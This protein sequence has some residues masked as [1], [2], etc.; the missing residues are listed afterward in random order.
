MSNNKP[1]NFDFS[2]MTKEEV[3]AYFESQNNKITKEYEKKLDSVNKQLKTS[4]KNLQTTSKKLNIKTK[5]L[6]TKTKELDSAN[7]K[8]KDQENIINSVITY[9]N[10]ETQIVNEIAQKTVAEILPLDVSEA[11]N[12]T[13]TLKDLLHECVTWSNKA[14]AYFEMSSLNKGNEKIPALSPKQEIDNKINDTKEA[15]DNAVSLREIQ[16]NQNILN[17]VT[18]AVA[19]YLIAKKENNEP[20]SEA[21]QNLIDIAKKNVKGKESKK[22]KSPG[23]QATGNF[24]NA[25]KCKSKTLDYCPECHG[26]LQRLSDITHNL[27]KDTSNLY[28][29]IEAI[30]EIEFLSYCDHCGKVFVYHDQDT[31]HPVLPNRTIDCRTLVN[32]SEALFMGIPLNKAIGKM[33]EKFNLGN[34]IIPDNLHDL[35]SIYFTPLYGGLLK[36]LSL[37]KTV[38][39]DETTFSV[40]EAQGKGKKTNEEIKEE[41]RLINEGQ[42]IN[43]KYSKTNYVIALSSGPAEGCNI[44]YYGFS[45]NRS[46]KS[47]GEI[48]QHLTSC[49]TLI[50]DGYGGYP[51]ILKKM[52]NEVKH[53]S[54]LVHMRR[55]FIR[56]L[57]LKKFLKDLN[58]AYG[59]NEKS[60]EDE[61]ELKKYIDSILK[62]N[63]NQC[64]DYYKGLFILVAFQKIYALESDIDYTDQSEENCTQIKQ[65]RADQRMLFKN[66]SA[67]VDELSVDIVEVNKNGKYKAKNRNA[68][69]VKPCVYFLNNKD[70]LSTFLDS[71]VVRPD[72]N[73][74]EGQIRPVTIIRKNVYQMNRIWGMEDLLKIYTLF[75]TLKLN[76]IEP[77]EFLNEYCNELYYYCYEKGLTEEYLKNPNKDITH[78]MGKKLDFERLSEGFDFEKYINLILK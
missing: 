38:Y 7:K 45:K 3:I 65:K 73:K 2:S 35:I 27:L 30:K 11:Q 8:V 19:D 69:F 24:K 71:T 29:V 32:L 42:E 59:D 10:N 44:A 4:E 25:R 41:L 33:K 57:D 76:K 64:P 9:I 63:N 40:S 62:G 77:I 50:T 26:K 70:S 5:E 54:C 37:C 20:L 55:E 75:Q 43:K 60:P 47:M 58:N 68:K 21:E 67:I 49:E 48:L 34:S 6:D 13:D 56:S 18:G 53:Q 46:A 74:V 16:K 36:R 14:K 66:I 12:I 51:A 78:I 1:K 15:I 17:K 22:K 72:T 61:A 28:N 31:H 52:D 39:C 23:K